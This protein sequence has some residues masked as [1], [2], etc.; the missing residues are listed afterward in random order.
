[1]R[2]NERGFTLIEMLLVLVITLFISSLF[3]KFTFNHLSSYTNYQIIHQ[4][5]LKIREYQFLAHVNE[6]YYRIYGFDDTFFIYQKN[7]WED[8]VYE[9]KIPPGMWV[10]IGHTI[11]TSSYMVKEDMTFNGI[12][13]FDV[14]I[15]N[16][17]YYYTMN[18]GKGRYTI[19]YVE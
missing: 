10:S 7:H 8:K 12:G 13:S 16:K 17:K 5:Q 1:M 11:N 19:R 14:K 18:M 4:L 9:Q 2:M 6:T 15:G 3:I